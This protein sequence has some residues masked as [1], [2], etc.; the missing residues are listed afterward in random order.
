[1]AGVDVALWAFQALLGGLKL[2]LALY[3]FWLVLD[4]LVL[5]AL[6]HREASKASRA[7]PLV[8]RV[9]RRPHAWGYPRR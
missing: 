4:L 2:A 6:A 1:M 9:R 7:L 3:L 5:R 8:R